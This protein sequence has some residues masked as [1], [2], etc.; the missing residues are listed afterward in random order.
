MGMNNIKSETIYDN[1][2]LKMEIT[3]EESLDDVIR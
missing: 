3:N 1:I 2:I